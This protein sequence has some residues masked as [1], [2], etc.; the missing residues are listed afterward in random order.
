[1]VLPSEN[2]RRVILR[3]A[4]S[5]ST[6]ACC[7]T[8][9]GGAFA[10]QADADMA[11]EEAAA[12]AP[13]PDGEAIIVTG[14][15]IRRDGFIAPTPTNVVTGEQLSLA[16]VTTVGDIAFKL[17]QFRPSRSVY[18][19]HTGGNVGGNYFNLRGLSGIPGPSRTL[20]LVD[21]RRPTPTGNDETFDVNVIPSGIVSR[22]EV[23]TGGASAAY[24][25]DAVAGVVNLILRDDID[26]FEGSLQA[27]QTFRYNDAK[28]VRG[29][30][31][32]G[33]RF[34]EGRGRLL[35]SGE[36]Y[37]NKGAGIVGDRRWAQPNWGLIVN[38]A[39]TPS[40]GQPAIITGR[41]AR[42]GNATFGGL[43]TSGPLAGTQFIE[44]GIATRFNPGSAPLGSAGTFGGDGANVGRTLPLLVPSERTTL[45][46]HLSYEVS[47]AVEVW[48]EASHARIFADDSDTI[49]SFNFGNIVIQRDNA[50]LPTSVRDA[51]AANSL[52]SFTMSRINQ[53]FGF[54]G[55][56]ARS[57]YRQFSGGIKGKFGDSWNWDIS[58]TNGRYLQR[59]NYAND[60][61]RANLTAATDA[62]VDPVTGRVVCRST[63][64]NPTNGCVPINLFG[65]GSPSQQAIDYVT[66]DFQHVQR[67]RQNSV[68]ASLR[69]EPFDLWAGPVSV[70]VGAA[71]R[72]ERVS[73]TVAPLTAAF[74][75][76]I[77]NGPSAGPGTIK[78]SEAF[79]EVVV[80]LL[81]DVPMFRSLDFN[82][83]VRV[84]DY[85][86]TGTIFAWK[87][88]LTNQI[89]P[90][91]RLRATLSRDIRAPNFAELSS[92]G[93]ATF[94][95]V[96][97]IDGTAVTV[98][99]PTSP[100]PNLRPEIGK[101]LTLGLI[102]EPQWASSLRASVDYFDI[103]LTGAITALSA[104][105]IINGC[106]AGQQELCNRLVRNPAGTLIQINNSRFNAQ[107]LRTKGV[108]FAL[109]YSLPLSNLI[110][111]A[112][113]RL[114]LRV[115]ASY[116]DTLQ[117]RL[118]G[119]QIENAGTAI[120]HWTA[121][122]S[123]G[124]SDDRTTV[125]LGGQY[126]GRV[127]YNAT[128]GSAQ[129]VGLDTPRF[130]DRFYLDLGFQHV[131]FDTGSTRVQLFGN[132]QNLL[133]KDPP[134]MPTLVGPV[135]PIISNFGLYD[136]LGRR[137][138]LGVRFKF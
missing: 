120:P 61:I 121:L 51:M 58:A 110:A 83:A 45:F 42:M 26:G 123:I 98:T 12:T 2:L 95:A 69:G 80:P 105:Q 126:M 100:N 6:L 117:S 135:S 65:A 132:I 23:V 31:S 63:L 50:Y 60:T 131:L 108:D 107:T 133:D 70:A 48:A 122:G 40:N 76:G 59:Q 47:D 10:Q 21:G 9:A 28:E 68:E 73:Y 4:G 16:G 43:I 104:Q 77:F 84:A 103:K 36:Y 39:Y 119:Q 20:T 136:P 32:F 35:L 106:G 5:V 128:P 29:D 96:R 94:A 13:E 99:V 89:F 19:S 101:T 41:D 115:S 46:G 116:T 130:A 114:N 85:S 27:G 22:V 125:Q 25:S 81:R 138:T 67:V 53:D 57:R 33:T 44:G 37:R 127:T 109:D 124:Y 11:V 72:S 97:D 18:T 8:L 93:A 112:G 30:L 7:T 64:I 102:Y 14:S 86:S 15:R 134:I 129:P 54:Y 34:A 55:N 91:L 1:M 88:G 52:A 62:V 56:T 113:G 78:V 87:L 71:H 38:P 74:A 111:D 90:D 118:L 66:D 92:T 17:P 49:P 79:A 24:G 82:G 75:H 137:F 3:I